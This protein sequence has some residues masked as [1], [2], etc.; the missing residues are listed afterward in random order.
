[1]LGVDVVA[2]QAE[3]GAGRV[4]PVDARA[5]AFR[6]LVGRHLDAS[7]GLACA[8]LHDRLEAE[9][10]VQDAA[11][12][13]WRGWGG[14]RDPAR[15]EAWFRRILVNG[16]RDRLR[17]RARR[18]VVDVGRELTEA[19]HPRTTDP[20]EP[21]ADRDLLSAAVD[22]L[23][24]DERIAIVLRFQADLTVPAIA[25]VLGVPEGTV[26]SRLHRALAAL[27]AS[28]EGTDR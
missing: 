1:M 24:P 21:L 6:A 28:L 10:A 2:E 9:D 4:T 14:L 3:R 7:Y 8:I 27:R 12:A 11:A 19:E 22:R 23:G 20:S 15:F 5:D 17:A 18:K 26:K 16:C 25:A 13:A